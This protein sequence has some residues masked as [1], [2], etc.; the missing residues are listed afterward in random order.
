MYGCGCDDG[1]ASRAG[2]GGPGSIDL[3]ALGTARSASGALS[4]NDPTFDP[5]HF[6]LQAAYASA[7]FRYS[8]TPPVG[9]TYDQYRA[10]MAAQAIN[11][12][13]S[14]RRGGGGTG[15]LPL[16]TIDAG[17]RY[18]IRQ[19]IAGKRLADAF[20]QIWG[21]VANDTAYP[22][23]SPESIAPTFT[24]GGIVLQ[25]PGGTPQAP[26]IDPASRLAVETSDQARIAEQGA[27]RKAEECKAQVEAASAFVND[28]EA[29]YAEYSDGALIGSDPANGQQ[30]GTKAQVRHNLQWTANQNVRR[31][32]EVAKFYDGSPMDCPAPFPG[33]TGPVEMTRG[34]MPDSGP[35]GVPPA[36]PQESPVTTGR[37]VT[38]P[39]SDGPPPTLN[40]ET[41]A[42]VPKPLG[43]GSL[44]LYAIIAY[45]A[46]KA[47]K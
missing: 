26:L 1:G 14:A 16:Y 11:A 36:I 25:W 34:R 35:Q 42:P 33:V 18:A 10:G 47:L 2:F 44:L 6:D 17:T 9:V 5:V 40:A 37:P 20:A 24:V 31:L 43:I 32:R 29:R 41:G 7:P 19:G 4:S 8:A 28:F 21:P 12:V 38:G 3:A 15:P 22:S 27:S 39:V 23:P 30:L 45:G 13:E 46:Y